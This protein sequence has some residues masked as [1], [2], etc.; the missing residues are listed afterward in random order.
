MLSQ[1]YFHVKEHALHKSIHRTSTQVVQWIL[2]FRILEQ[3]DR[4]LAVAGRDSRL[5]APQ[6]RRSHWSG[7]TSQ[8]LGL[9]EHVSLFV[10][11][12]ALIPSVGFYPSCQKL[13]L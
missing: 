11:D 13:L 5:A 1:Y 4:Q 10:A 9:V 7:C 2:H 6:Q 12:H 8:Q 3:G